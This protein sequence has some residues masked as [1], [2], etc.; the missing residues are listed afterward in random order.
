MSK[1]IDDG[2]S[3]IGYTED[4]IDYLDGEIKKQFYDDS[5]DDDEFHENCE[6]TIGVIEE[7]RKKGDTDFFKI[8]YDTPTGDYVVKRL[9]EEENW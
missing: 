7:M 9:I 4:I 3:I 1:I 8:I 2:V 6:K 5:L